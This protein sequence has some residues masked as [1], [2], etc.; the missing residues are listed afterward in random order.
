MTPS[1]PRIARI[2]RR[3]LPAQVAV[4]RRAPS[5]R[6]ADP[7]R[8]SALAPH[9]DRLRL[10]PGRPVARAGEAARELVVVLAGEAIAV[11][12][13]GRRT[14]LGPGTELGAPEL[15][16]RRPTPVTVIAGADLE[17]LVVNGPAVRWAYAEGL[18]RMLDTDAA[19]TS[20]AAAPAT[21]AAPPAP[22]A[23]VDRVRTAA[24]QPA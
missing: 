17:V 4:L 11:H 6:H 20:A 14:T 8:L 18:A 13:D 19:R 9:S 3:R 1:L 23:T 24:T 2:V 22:A 7:R 5:L 10:P 16:A 21:A 15:L 12:P